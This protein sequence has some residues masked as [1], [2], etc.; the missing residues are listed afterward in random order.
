MEKSPLFRDARPFAIQRLFSRRRVGTAAVAIGGVAAVGAMLGSGFTAGSA[1]RPQEVTAS[2]SHDTSRD[3]VRSAI[4]G[5]PNLSAR[6]AQALTA[7]FRGTST[8]RASPSPS[9]HPSK[10]AASA[11]S[12]TIVQSPAPEAASPEEPV[13]T[14]AMSPHPTGAPAGRCSAAQGACP[15]PAVGAPISAASA[16][17]RPPSVP[18]QS[19]NGQG[20]W[21]SGGPTATA[22]PSPSPSPSPTAPPTSTVTPTPPPPPPPRRFGQ[23]TSTATTSPSS[24][25]TAWAPGR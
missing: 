23:D 19:Q 22:T 24:A 16:P 18:G 15:A 12:T 4:G 8:H 3:Q 1:P 25:A 20:Q 6:I 13:Q 21:Q 17:G 5:S 10:V 2:P 7:P 14:L 11:G 9:P